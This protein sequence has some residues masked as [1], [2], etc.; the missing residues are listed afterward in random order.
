MGGILGMKPLIYEDGPRR[1]GL[2][3]RLMELGR[4]LLVSFGVRLMID[5]MAP[6]PSVHGCSIR[7]ECARSEAARACVRC[8]FTPVSIEVLPARVL[9]C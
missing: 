2:G 6:S 1:Q 8:G 9:P 7:R 5:V 3:D 4:L